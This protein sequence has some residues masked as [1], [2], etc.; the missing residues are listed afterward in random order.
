MRSALYLPSLLGTVLLFH[1]AVCGAQ[2]PDSQTPA[3]VLTTRVLMTGSSDNSQP[4]GYKVYSTFALEAALRRSLDHRFASELTIRTESREV[5]SL[6]AS[7][8]DKRL[9]SLELLPVN[10]FIQFRPWT[11][12][13]LRPYAG[14]GV[15][16]TVAWE[17]SGALDSTDMAASVGPAIGLG[18]DLN[19]G[20]QTLLN[21]DLK[22]N[23]FTA[24]LR[25]GDT[26]LTDIQVDPL[27]LGVGV[28][29]RF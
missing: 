23:S 4:A 7:G 1:P 12:G 29:F 17:K 5:D 19:L 18:A 6:V 27:A 13:R 24:K 14:A 26:P 22:W 11:G 25:N 15:N 20:L 16:L 8:E 9:G 28:G 3:W 2:L 10:L 21:L